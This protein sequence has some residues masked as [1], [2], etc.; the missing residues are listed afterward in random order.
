MM[1]KPYPPIYYSDYLEL[2]K[3]LSAQHPKSDQYN[4]KAHEEHLFII[5][6]QAY[7]LWFKQILH[8]I[9]SVS[10]MFRDDIIDERSIGVAV[11]RIFRVTEIQR[12]L[13]EQLRVLET[14][15]PL[16]FLEF[17]D[18][19]IPASGFQS[20]QFR[21][22]ENKLGLTDE[23]RVQ[24]N[25]VDYLKTL[26][27][28]HRKMVTDTVQN[29]SLFELVQR[30]L[31]R[32]PFLHYEEFDFWT[33]YKSA[34]EKMLDNDRDIIMNN[35]TLTEKK[36]ENQLIQIEKTK[37]YFELLFEDEKHNELIKKGIKRL[38]GRATMA[39]LFI[40][41][42]RDEPILHMPFRF[43]NLLIEMDELFSEW[44]YRHAL[45]VQ[46]MIGAKV[47]TGGSSGHQYLMSTIDKHRI[48]TDLFNLSSY[49]IPRSERP[50]LPEGLVKDLSFCYTYKEKNKDS[51][52]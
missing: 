41:M 23:E 19:L 49:L 33:K 17:R 4:H 7:E 34:V 5:V 13:I 47:G 6:H 43:L 1:D 26:N 28:N 2:D 14:M 22:I 9:D 40:N 24:Y 48:F 32:T 51:A 36:R 45:M 37:E 16:D 30:W 21:L 50:E 27:E 31:E 18:F 39:A 52:N 12:L 10:T 25:N 42:Y 11:S 29:P 3:L 35:P 8:E 15:T 44:R 20:F 38:S 46:R